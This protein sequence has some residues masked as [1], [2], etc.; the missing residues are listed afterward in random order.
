[1]WNKIVDGYSHVSHGDRAQIL[2][3]MVTIT[4]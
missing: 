3:L 1:M 4:I 2:S